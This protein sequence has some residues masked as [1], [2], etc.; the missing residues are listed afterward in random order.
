MIKFD[1][2]L[3]I[4]YRDKLCCYEICPTVYFMQQYS[5]SQYN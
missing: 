4:F 2:I 1:L 3:F 5:E